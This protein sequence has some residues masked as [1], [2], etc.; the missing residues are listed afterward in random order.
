[1]QGVEDVRFMESYDSRHSSHAMTAA[2][3][4]CAVLVAISLLTWWTS[5]Q[6]A[7]QL[8]HHLYAVPGEEFRHSTSSSAPR[9][10][11]KVWYVPDSI[12]H[13][14]FQSFVDFHTRIVAVLVCFLCP[15]RTAL[16]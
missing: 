2:V 3:V 8:I 7:E 5:H 6:E 15:E 4:S 11:S 10:P 1:M 12:L 9:Q 16:L 13:I 14:G